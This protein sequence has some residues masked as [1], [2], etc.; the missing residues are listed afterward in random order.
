MPVN[1]NIKLINAERE[2]IAA[3]VTGDFYEGYS[4][5]LNLTWN[6]STLKVEGFDYYDCFN[7]LRAQLA[8]QS[9]WL[10]CKGAARQFHHSGMSRDMTNGTRGYWLTLGKPASMDQ[11]VGIFDEADT[12]DIVDEATQNDFSA[13]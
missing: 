7:K 6:Q 1:E 9:L 4:V 13:E 8:A 5:Y 12:I 3:H 10:L 2:K 11:V